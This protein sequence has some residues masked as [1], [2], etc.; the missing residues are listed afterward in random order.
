[1]NF[2][3]KKR[4]TN[5]FSNLARVAAQAVQRP[6]PRVDCYMLGNLQTNLR[7]IHAPHADPDEPSRPRRPSATIQ[8]A[9]KAATP[10][11]VF[12]FAALFRRRPR[13]G[14]AGSS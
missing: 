2:K 9:P 13:S 14:T 10:L 4:R 5:L 1:V 3:A 8:A 12:A 7:S 6:M 11:I